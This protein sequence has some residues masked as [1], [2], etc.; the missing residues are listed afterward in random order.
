FNV[1]RIIAWLIGLLAGIH[2]FRLYGPVSDDDIIYYF[3]F[4]PARL[5][6]TLPTGD[7]FLEQGARYWTLVTYSFLHADWLHWGFNSIWMLAFGTPVAR[8]LGASRFLLLSALGSIGGAL[9]YYL[10][11]PNQIAVLIGAS[12]AVSAQVAAASRLIFA[13]PA[14]EGAAGD[15]STGRIRPLTLG[16]TFT[17]RM[18]LMFILV[19]LGLKYVFGASGVGLPAGEGLVAWE[20][21]LGGFF[22]GLLLFGLFDRKT[23]L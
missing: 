8:R 17:S 9:A 2:L 15:R 10:F 22:A 13:R 1:P 14:A 5:G 16:E 11:H 12:A 21:H 6:G 3:A 7:S 4:I 18:P 23:S 19:W 20:A